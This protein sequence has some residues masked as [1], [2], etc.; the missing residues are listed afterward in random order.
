[1]SADVAIVTGGASGVGLA[2][3][4]LLGS[5]GVKVVAIDRAWPES[6]DP[7]ANHVERVAGDVTDDATWSAALAAASAHGGTSMLVLNAAKLVLGTVLD[8]DEHTFRSVIDVN[9][10]AAVKALRAVLPDMISRG[11]GSIVGVTST[12]S[13][14]AEQGLAA[15]AT[16]KAALLQLLRSVAVDHA[17]A[18]IRTNAVCPGAIDTPFFRRHVDAAPDPEAFL[19][20]KTERHPSGRI[21]DP[22][23]VA[24]AIWFLLSDHSRGMNGVSVMV[25]GGL[26]S[27]FDFVAEGL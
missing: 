7:R 4:Q 11:R 5:H 14:F 9:V 15:Y 26:T 27:T 6:I 22:A 17:R 1:M 25:D 8:L 21:L 3:V 12:S 13:L 20:H 18:G 16:S 10:I 19:R 24:E 2:T 23:D